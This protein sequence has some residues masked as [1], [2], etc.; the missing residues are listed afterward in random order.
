MPYDKSP[1]NCASSLPS[2]R[3]QKTRPPP[4]NDLAPF[5]LRFDNWVFPDILDLLD[6]T[7]RSLVARTLGV[8]EVAGSNPVVPT[9]QKGFPVRNRKAFVISATADLLFTSAVFWLS[10][11]YYC[12]LSGGCWQVSSCSHCWSRYSCFWKV[13]PPDYSSGSSLI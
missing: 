3:I 4:K 5:Q 13:P 12:S 11:P 6:G 2:S 9:N 8:R 7:W 1:L 10:P